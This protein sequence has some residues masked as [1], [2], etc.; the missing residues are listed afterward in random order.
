MTPGVCEA[1]VS[2]NP[3]AG[4][5]NCPRFSVTSS[6]NPGDTFPVGTTVVTYVVTDNSGN[7]AQCSFNIHVF[8]NELPTITCP[9][10]ITVTNDPGVCEAVVSWNPPAGADNCPGFSVTSSH[11]PGDTFLVGTTVVTYVVT[12]NSGNQAQ[13]SF[14]I[15]VFDNELPTITCPS[16]ITVTNDP[17]VCVAVVSWNPPAGADNCP[18][19]SVTSSHNPGDTFPVGTTVVTYVVTDNSGN[20]AQCNFNIHV[21]DNENPTISCASD[22]N[23]TNDPGVCEAVVSWNPPT[24]ADNCPG[25]SVTSSHNPG[26]TFPVGTTVVTY[27]VTDNSGNQAQCSFNINV[28][29]SELPTITCPSDITVTNDP[30]VCEAVVSWNPPTG[31]DNCPGFSVTSSHNPG[32]T[33]P[34]GTTVVTY[35]VT[36]NSGNQAQCSFNINVIDS[37]LP[38]ITCPSDI[39]VTN[40][41]GVCEAVVSW[42]PPAGADNCPGFSVTNSHNQT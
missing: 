24:G 5:D 13:C 1:V 10:D 16:D 8:D 26:D 3:P 7:Q 38:T 37:E 14:N 39:T 34:V 4:A 11:N 12:D 22:I 6:H 29:D 36:D 18:G 19:F 2:W 30:G 41:P 21:F 23:V 27:V 20:Q 25:F 31:A 28:I 33:F 35:V 32:D 17:G 15:H 9:S 40:D 42:N